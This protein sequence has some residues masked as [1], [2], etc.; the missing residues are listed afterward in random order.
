MALCIAQSPLGAVLPWT[1]FI[2]SWVVVA[3]VGLLVTDNRPR[4]D[5]EVSAIDPQI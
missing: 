4:R 2:L 5:I 3:K 1:V